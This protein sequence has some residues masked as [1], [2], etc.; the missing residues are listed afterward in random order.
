MLVGGYCVTTSNPGASDQAR[1]L[2]VITA[3][4]GI[5]NG[6]TEI[7]MTRGGAGSGPR[8]CSSR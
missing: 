2:C 7:E 4:I 3:T 1:R 6:E 8:T 5:E